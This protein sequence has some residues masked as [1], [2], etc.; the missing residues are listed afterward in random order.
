MNDDERQL[1]EHVATLKAL[2]Q[3]ERLTTREVFAQERAEQS[4]GSRV[5][6]G[7]ALSHAS[8]DET[9][10]APGGRARLWIRTET[11]HI[12][13][14]PGSPVRLTPNADPATSHRGTVARLRAAALSIVVDS[15]ALDD[16]DET[17]DV[18]LEAPEATFDRGDRALRRILAEPS[19]LAFQ[20]FG[21]HAR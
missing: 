13:M 14:R 12:R 19:E 17:F 5:R 4:L 20:L 15:D 11:E 21:V 8:I 16:L 2:W 9:D 6:R 7:L 3:R 18:E 10:A 1:E